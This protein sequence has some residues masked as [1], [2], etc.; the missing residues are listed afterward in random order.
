M[1]HSAHYDR[2]TLHVTIDSRITTEA[3]P[4]HIVNGDDNDWHD[5]RI[6][7]IINTPGI[8]SPTNQT[9]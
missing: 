8:T 6:P 7:G 4:S 3:N 9:V 2:S 5:W 1:T